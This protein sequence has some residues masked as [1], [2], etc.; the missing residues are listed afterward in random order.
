MSTIEP[1]ADGDGGGPARVKQLLA[2]G[3]Q[4]LGG[5][6]LDQTLSLALDGLIELA[7]AERGMI[8]LYGDD[9]QAQFEE[10]RNLDRQDIARPE[11][12]VSRTILE[13]VRKDGRS[14]W[15]MNALADDTLG[16]RGSVMRLQ[17]L[18]VICLPILDAGKPLGVVYMDNRSAAEV[19]QP[20]TRDLVES[21]ADLISLA[22][23]HALE[24]RRLRLRVT[25]LAD[26]LRTQYRF[27]AILGHDD[28]FFEVLRL[29]SQVADSEASVLIQGESGTGKE[30][31]AKAIHHNSA[32][33]NH[34]FVAV[35]C[36]A[37]PEALLESE[38]FGHQRGAFTGAVADHPGWF[39]RARGG[40]L[41]LDEVG[42]M[43]PAMQVKLL[44]V[45]ESG[46]YARL[47]SA[48][49]RRADVRVVAATNRDLRERVAAGKM[50]QDLLYRLNVI[51]IEVPPLRDRP[52][53]IPLL[54]R[55]FVER[56]SAER[57]VELRLSA[58]AERLLLAYD[59][60]GNI[61]ELQNVIQRAVLVARGP[62]IEPQDLPEALRASVAARRGAGA[63]SF[64]LAKRR[65]IE[66]FE[67]A[68]ICRGLQAA[69]GNISRAAQAAGIDFKNFHSKMQRYQI[70]PAAYKPG[71]PAP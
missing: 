10:A 42:E 63:S 16:S 34:P 12:E 21:F 27:D 31:V 58:R 1:R 55:H 28:A 36:G 3:R 56:W 37:L 22:A 11:F 6:D 4:I 65:V 13:T 61:R 52:T 50:R 2:I 44:R 71:R 18:S 51:E 46:E 33:R 57:R 60:P 19:F 43:S 17:I 14:F 53:D 64:R 48:A 9:G 59:Y 24:R 23:A 32:R 45:L 41:F 20:E 30:L 26:Q 38:L 39:E 40:T 49:V 7:G 47:G 66:E 70:D 62:E 29:I 5:T 68:Y 15:S 8:V 69:G 25:E 35:N 54:A 67:R